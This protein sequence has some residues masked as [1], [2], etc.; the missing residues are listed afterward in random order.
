MN[1]SFVKSEDSF[2]ALAELKTGFHQALMEGP[3]CR[4]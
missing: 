1:L 2:E 3:L 4:E